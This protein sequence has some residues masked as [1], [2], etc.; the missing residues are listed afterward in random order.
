MYYLSG[1][2]LRQLFLLIGG[3]GILVLL[4]ILASPYRRARLTTF[5]D[6]T[7]DPQGSSYHIN[8][9]LLALGS[10]GIDGVGLGRSRQKFAYLPEATTDSIFA[11]IGEETGFIGGVVL[12]GLL[13]AL[14]LAAFQIAHLASNRYHQLLAAGI[15]SWL[16]A[17]TML[18]LAAMVALVPLTGI[19]L[20][21][22]SYGGS[23][24]VAALSSI[25]LLVNIAR[26]EK[27]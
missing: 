9:V 14:V 27:I 1:A 16:A 24:L 12:I 26:T 10:G 21:F 18:N 25:G 5:L 17:Q 6:P 11:V 2:P 7:S 8:Q 20:P 23:A 22:V 4:L 19:P 3:A 15:A 13:L